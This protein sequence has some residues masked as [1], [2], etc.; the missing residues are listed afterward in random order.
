MVH[1]R[2]WVTELNRTDG[3]HMFASIGSVQSLSHV[4]LFVTPWTVALQA[5][6]SITN[7]WSLLKLMPIESVM[8][9]NHLILCCPLLP[10]SPCLQSFLASGFFLMSQ[11]FP[12][13]GRST[14]VSASASA[15]SMNIQDWFPLELTGLI[16]LQSKGLSRVFSKRDS[17]EGLCVC[18]FTV[19]YFMMHQRQ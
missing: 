1:I 3:P 19:E 10:F 12:S 17:K 14:G 9:L 13:S 16:S 8:P 5:S 15:L 6:L 2:Y 4:R 18:Y 7:S 11:F